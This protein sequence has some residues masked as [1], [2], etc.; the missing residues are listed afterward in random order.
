MTDNAVLHISY[1]NGR[2]HMT[3]NTLA[4]LSEQGIR[5]IRKL[6]KLIESS[7]TP[8]ELEKL[9]NILREEISTFDLRL[10]ELANRGANARTRYKEL[11]PELERLVY[12]R[13]RYKKSDQRYKDLMLR[14]KAVRESIRHEKA[15]YHS[16]VSDFKRLSRNKEKFNKIAKEILP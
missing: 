8:D 5:N 1:N 13:E 6:I 12:Q 14:V 2:G 9:H 10:K 16:A 3:V 11:E 7:D 15:V 4:F